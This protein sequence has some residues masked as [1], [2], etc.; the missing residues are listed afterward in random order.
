MLVGK[1]CMDKSKIFDVSRSERHTCTCSYI[2]ASEAH[3]SLYI[4]YVY[5]EQR[6]EIDLCTATCRLLANVD[7]AE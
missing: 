1:R 5:N 3:F 2:Y 4:I 7:S 6:I